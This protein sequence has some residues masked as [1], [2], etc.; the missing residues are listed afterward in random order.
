MLQSIISLCGLG[1][2]LIVIVVLINLK[3]DGKLTFPTLDELEKVARIVVASTEQ[4]KVGFPGA[5]KYV[6]AL[7]QL[8]AMGLTQGVDPT[9]VHHA[10][11]A[12]VYGIKILTKKDGLE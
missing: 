1:V 8:E 11:E 6:Y 4:Q 7:E 3:R 5:E 12:A 9:L 2:A 10:I